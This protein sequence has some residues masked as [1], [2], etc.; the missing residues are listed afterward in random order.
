MAW[1]NIKALADELKVKYEKIDA[2]LVVLRDK[3][4]EL[5]GRETVPPEEIDAVANELTSII[6]DMDDNIHTD[7]M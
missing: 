7:S 6:S 3:I 4:K 5:A 2:N 1:S